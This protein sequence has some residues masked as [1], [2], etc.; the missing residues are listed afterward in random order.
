MQ[1]VVVYLV[2]PL[3]TATL[4]EAIM[5]I[6]KEKTVFQA[7]IMLSLVVLV[8]IVGFIGPSIANDDE[9]IEKAKITVFDNDL[10]ILREIT[11][12]E[13]VKDIR[14]M[15]IKADVIDVPP[16]MNWTHKIDI[17]VS[18]LKGRWLYNSADGLLSKL[19]KRLK[20]SYRIQSNE[21]FKELL[22]GI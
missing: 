1:L 15:I 12:Y 10:K 22:F 18:K 16:N 14:M 6:F 20:P 4:D 8:L 5:N 19:N 17:S 21:K 11:E 13:N 3:V 2:T 7:T 9:E